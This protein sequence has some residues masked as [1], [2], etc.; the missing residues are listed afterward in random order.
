MAGI[1]ARIAAV[2]PERSLE[3]SRIAIRDLERRLRGALP[4]A[5]QAR[6]GRLAGLAQVLETLSPL[7][8]LSRG[9]AIVRLLPDRRVLRRAQDAAPGDLVETKLAE[10]AVIARIEETKER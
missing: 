5:I 4:V 2:S 8:T 3:R 10:G 7:A 1:S 6:R 9:Y